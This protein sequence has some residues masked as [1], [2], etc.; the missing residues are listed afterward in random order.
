MDVVVA[1]APGSR[2]G[3]L[4]LLDAEAA[5]RGDRAAV[6]AGETWAGLMERAAGHLARGVVDLAGHGY[7]LRVAIV[8]GKGNNGGDGWAAARRLR[9]YGA[10]P[11]VVSV[12]P[13]DVELRDEASQNR[14]RWRA[15]GGRT[16]TLEELDLALGWADI[17][18]DCLLGTGVSGPPR[19]E[20][21]EA[22]RALLAAHEAGLPV[23]ACD[24]PSGVDADTGAAP[25][26][27]VR[28]D[29]TVTFG[30]WKRGLLL[31][32]GRQHAGRV[33]LG[34]L[35]PRYAAPD[36]GWRVLT[37]TGAVPAPLE[38][39]AD[40]RD[41][42][43]I[44][45]VAGSE[46]MAGAAALCTRGA[47]AAGG[48]L[49]TTLTTESARPEVATLA[50]AA[51]TAI[52][53]S[54]TID[55]HAGRSDVVVAG[56]GMRPDPGTRAEVER[57][58]R[59][60]RLVVLDADAINVFRDDAEALRDR[61]GGLVLTP[62]ERELARLLGVDPETAWNER[63]ARV[64][65]LSQRLGATI[66]AKGPGTVV[67]AQDGRVWVTPTGGPALGT[68][69]TGDVLSGMIGAFVARGTDTP[70]A[71]ARA[72][73]LHGLA[74]DLAA[75]G[76]GGLATTEGVLAGIPSALEW[77]H[78]LAVHDPLRPLIEVAR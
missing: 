19:G 30:G 68:G 46:G 35:G 9:R 20:V 45:V 36:T 7:G 43:V 23:V 26:G 2:P 3:A 38:P 69:G 33:V 16:S 57:V 53:S 48:G 17:A 64:P 55:E 12:P 40:K 51:M 13:L 25:A 21:A 72:C 29:L 77:L 62:H 56:P 31:H 42:G 14:A 28:A 39:D 44:A 73:W 22:C 41:R 61:A 59:K 5:R 1:P 32:P 4:S 66:V 52:V 58:L 74:G 15:S 50:P 71:V 10:Q 37:A 18:V 24:V 54:E 67:A 75:R 34:S 27:S 11:W 76:A 65:E 6:D 60:A 70:L 78:E 49:V 47:L 8:V 63:V